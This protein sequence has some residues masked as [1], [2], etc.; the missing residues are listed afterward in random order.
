M[1]SPSETKTK[2]EWSNSVTT[3]Q[4]ATMKAHDRLVSNSFPKAEEMQKYSLSQT[5]QSMLARGD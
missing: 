5:K 1:C 4:Y 2:T 3:K